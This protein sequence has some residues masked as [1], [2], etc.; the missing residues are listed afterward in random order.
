MTGE[1][2]LVKYP[3]T[4]KIVMDWFMQKMLESLKDSDLPKE[5]KEFA[6]EMGLGEEK[7]G[8]LIDSAPRALFEIFDTQKVYITIS[9]SKGVPV[10]FHYSINEDMDKTF[11]LTR[12]EAEKIGVEKA[13]EILE[14]KL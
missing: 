2:L 6:S 4:G 14:M 1:E 9:L 3:K 12:S 13:F 5:F 7:V 8:K 10:K 11:Y